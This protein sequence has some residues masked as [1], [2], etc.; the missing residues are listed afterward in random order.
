MYQRLGPTKQPW[1]LLNRAI[2]TKWLRR[3][4]EYLIILWIEC[5][6][7]FF[8]ILNEIL[9]WF[10]LHGINYFMHNKLPKGFDG[11]YFSMHIFNNGF[12]MLLIKHIRQALGAIGNSNNL[13]LIIDCV[14]K[15]HRTNH[16]VYIWRWV[17][18]FELSLELTRK[19]PHRLCLNRLRNAL[20]VTIIIIIKWEWLLL[21]S[22]LHN[23]KSMKVVH[24]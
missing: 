17:L 16:C 9:W 5:Q 24:I 14:N 2:P 11:Q 3:I 8:F 1:T 19:S 22:V 18:S 6:L 12:W 21:A 4:H 20:L 15:P 23:N 10:W 7:V 13:K